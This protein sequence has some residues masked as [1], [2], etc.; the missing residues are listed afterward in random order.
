M[1]PL[2]EA[3][4]KSWR[5]TSHLAPCNRT[6]INARRGI[7]SAAPAAFGPRKEPCQNQ[8]VHSL[9][10]LLVDKYVASLT[11]RT[12]VPDRPGG[13]PRLPVDGPNTILALLGDGVHAI[14]PGRA[15][16]LSRVS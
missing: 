6:H 15:A 16:L 14:R 3:A 11:I 4:S 1:A 7:P 2:F 9:A 5:P 8:S 13:F 10:G 12:S